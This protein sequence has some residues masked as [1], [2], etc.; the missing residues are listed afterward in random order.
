MDKTL[1]RGI[2]CLVLSWNERREG[3]ENH[4]V[5]DWDGAFLWLCLFL[6]QLVAAGIAHR[7]DRSGFA[8]YLHAVRR[9]Y[10]PADGW[11][12]DEPTAQK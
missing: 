7:K 10:L 2:P 3:G 8:L 12:M 9:L 6:S 4:M 1:L 5:E 11:R